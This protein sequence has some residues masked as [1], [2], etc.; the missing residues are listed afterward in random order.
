[1]ATGA[2]C[3]ALLPRAEFDHDAVNLRDPSAESVQT[4]LELLDERTQSPWNIDVVAPDLESARAIADRVEKLD[5]VDHTVTILDYVPKQQEEKLEVLADLALFLPMD[6]SFDPAMPA[7]SPEAQLE[8]LGEFRDVLREGWAATGADPELAASAARLADTLDRVLARSREEPAEEVLG[9]LEAQLVGPLPDQLRRFWEALS[10]SEEGVTLGDL[11]RDLVSRMLASDGRARIQVL[12]AEDL[13]E[14]GAMRRFVDAVRSLYPDATGMA[15]SLLETADVVVRSLREALAA[16]AVVIL[17]LLLFLWRRPAHALLV[18]APLALAGAMTGATTVITGSP[19]NFA[20]VIVLPLLLGIGADSG[21]HLVHRYRL[22]HA[23]A[24]GEAGADDVLRTST[25]RAILFSALTTIGSFGT[26]AFVGHQGLASLGRL[27]T[28]GIF[29][30]V[31]CNLVVLPAMLAG[32]TERE[33]GA[34]ALPAP[35]SRS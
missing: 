10:P 22:A 12:P 6:P 32:R 18:M 31:I 29:Y 14:P 7:P 30:T 5:V 17:L 20:N 16:A 35:S 9:R 26:M 24:D 23:R 15:P 28:V 3:L 34:E 27:L 4:M 1:V 13:H 21:I 8:L 19:F 11:P 25:V 2:G 33:G